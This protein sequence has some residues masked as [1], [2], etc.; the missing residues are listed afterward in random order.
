VASLGGTAGGGRVGKYDAKTGEAI[1]AEF[2]TGL[3]LPFGLAVK[4]A[5]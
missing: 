2:I 4:S 5:K 1:K 3:N